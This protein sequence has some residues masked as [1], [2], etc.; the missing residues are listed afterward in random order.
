MNQSL[1]DVQTKLNHFIDS[2]KSYWT[3]NATFVGSLTYLQIGD[4]YKKLLAKVENLKQH[5]RFTAPQRKRLQ[6]I[7]AAIVSVSP[8]PAQSGRRRVVASR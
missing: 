8:Q 7:T 2:R 1:R 3:T 6:D 5:H 4:P